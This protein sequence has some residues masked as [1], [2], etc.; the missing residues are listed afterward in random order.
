[1]Q[2]G[3]PSD[4]DNFC[5]RFKWPMDALKFFNIIKDDGPEHL[6]IDEFPTQEVIMKKVP[7]FVTITIQ[8]LEHV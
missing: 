8:D 7:R 2:V 6:I 4:W 5:A 3:K 1:M